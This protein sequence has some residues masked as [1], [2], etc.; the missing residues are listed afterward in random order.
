MLRF[1]NVK[2][3]CYPFCLFAD[4]EPLQSAL[5]APINSIE[6]NAFLNM[7]NGWWKLESLEDYDVEDLEEC[8]PED[9]IDNGYDPVEGCTVKDVGWMKVAF[10]DNGLSGFFTMGQHGEWEALYERPSEICYHL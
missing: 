1:S 5:Q 10:R 2:A 3:A 6:K 9:L 8:E 7:L 4:K